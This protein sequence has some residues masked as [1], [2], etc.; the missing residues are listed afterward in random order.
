MCNQLVIEGFFFPYYWIYLQWSDLK[1]HIPKVCTD[2]SGLRDVSVALETYCVSV[3]FVKKQITVKE[4]WAADEWTTWFEFFE[5]VM[6][7]IFTIT[8]MFFDS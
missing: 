6:K 1:R 8:F 5:K 7:L 3:V 4:K 2:S